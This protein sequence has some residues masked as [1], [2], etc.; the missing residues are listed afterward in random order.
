MTDNLHKI[1]ELVLFKEKKSQFEAI[2]KEDKYKFEKEEQEDKIQIRYELKPIGRY[3]RYSFMVINSNKSPITEVKIK[4][5]LPNF[6]EVYRSSP[7][8][9]E[10]EIL[11]KNETEV[12][13]KF[14]EIEGRSNKQINLYLIPLNLNKD[15]EIRSFLTFINTKDL[16]RVIN[17]DPI[18]IY[19]PELAIENLIIP[20]SKIPEIYQDKRFK[21][22]LISLGVV[23][24][25][26]QDLQVYLDNMER[27][28]KLLN[29]QFITRDIDNKVTWYFG[30]CWNK[31]KI[32]TT[33]QYEVLLI[34]QI[35]SGK[36]EFLLL[37]ENQD[38]LVS[39]STLVFNE[40]KS[41]IMH[42]SSIKS[43]NQILNLE[44]KSCGVVLPYL[45]DKGEKITCN[46]CQYQQVIW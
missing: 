20:S 16:V 41:V 31:N 18:K 15:G 6:M 7:P 2:K 43:E 26:T 40:F 33:K 21:K 38:Y 36:I 17:S 42:K 3:Y 1:Q 24:K 19:I 14:N 22:S 34:G 35:I 32:E 28:L 27:K 23:T 45:P 11:K 39:L 13:V 46:K 25:R 44:C 4:I 37:C 9:A 10:T 5:I 30:T 29:F 8:T 12:K